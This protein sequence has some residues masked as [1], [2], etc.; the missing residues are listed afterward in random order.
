MP[1]FLGLDSS[2]Q[3]LSA[4]VIEVKSS[5]SSGEISR[6]IVHE[7]SLNFDREFPGYGT[8]SGVLPHEDPAVVHSSPV[9][10]AEA[11]DTIFGRLREAGV[12][13]DRIDAISG[14]GQQ[15]GSVYLREGALEALA[16]LDPER[17][18]APQVEPLLSRSTSPI[19]MDSSTSSQCEAITA[20]LGGAQELAELTGSRAFERFTGPQIRKFHETDPAAYGETARIH[21]VSSFLASLLLGGDAAIDPGDGSGMNLLDLAEGNWSPAALEATAPG[22]GE[23]LP[24]VK[25]SSTVLGTV[26]E[27]FVQRHGLSKS[28]AVVAW[29]GDNPS[30][31]IGLGLVEPGHVAISLGTSDTLFG[32]MPEMRVDEGGEGHVFGAPTGDFM[33]L[34][35]FLNGSL[36]REEVR[37]RH[38]LDWA[39]FDRALEATPPGNG[40]GV[41]LPWFAPEITPS[42]SEPGPRYHG[43]GPEETERE[44]R[45]V[46][47]A[48]AASMALHSRWMGVETK[49]ILATGGASA[50]RRILQ[51][52][53][54]VFGAEVRP[55]E[56]PQTSALGAAL[57]A[58]HAWSLDQGRE[59]PWPRIVA[60]QGSGSTG[61]V[62]RPRPELAPLYG[63][64]LE[65][66]RACEAHAL[67]GG[68]DP[69]ALR[70]AFTK[71]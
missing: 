2:T 5:G 45:A 57:R 29:T 9:L 14:A 38:G 17:P 42:V 69:E 67:E 12:P 23:K 13:L 71:A 4:I 1:L 44:V 68:P 6:E 49:K 24:E 20:A 35:C 16:R 32:Y 47:E 60:G 34:I 41:L 51:V 66:Y 65:L 8:K 33:S 62:I 40:G 10:W 43:L 59:V 55:S 56:V 36:A 26:S 70:E 27:Y 7:L 39:A 19:W 48:Q 46:V 50:N 61:E 63:R 3:S 30:S 11:L 22:L 54:D 18:L 37:D 64:F 21:L 28:T 58:W 25:P 52:L 31:L 15:H 53:A